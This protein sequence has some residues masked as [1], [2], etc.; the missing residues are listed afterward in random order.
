MMR[1]EKDYLEAIYNIT[2]EKDYARTTDI[3]YYL[4]IKPAS[5]T[6]MLQKLASRGFIDYK[7]YEGATLTKD[8]Y[9]IG[10]AVS[11][12]HS[13]ILKLLKMLQVPE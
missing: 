5:A 4:K 9:K 2:K 3:A 12:R 6:E 1:R 11:E 7:K 13:A 10:K 8:G